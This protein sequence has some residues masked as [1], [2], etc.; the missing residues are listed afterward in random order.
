MKE[1]EITEVSEI[2]AGHIYRCF[3]EEFSNTIELLAEEI[4][5]ADEYG[6]TS[7]YV[8]D[9]RFDTYE[10]EIVEYI[11]DSEEEKAQWIEAHK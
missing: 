4:E 9:Y 10:H 2:K 3:D 8:N 1:V 5:P 11:F 6:S 7:V